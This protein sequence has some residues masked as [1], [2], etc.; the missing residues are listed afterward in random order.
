MSISSHQQHLILVTERVS[1][2]FSILG[3]SFVIITFL[4][5]P[6]F[7][8]P[9]NRMVFYASWGNLLSNVATMISRSGIDAGQDSSLCQSQSFLIQMFMPADSLWTFAMACNVYFT[10]RRRFSA[11]QLQKL[12]WKYF[13]L[14]YGIPAIPALVFLFIST[15]S[16]GR[17]YGPAELWCWISVDWDP[18][19]IACFYGPVWLIFLVTS[20]I[21]VS[22][23]LEIYKKRRDLR[24]A[25]YSLPTESDN[26]GVKTMEIHV[27]SHGMDYELDNVLASKGTDTTSASQTSATLSDNRQYTVD[28]SSSNAKQ[29][30]RTAKKLS[31]SDAAAWA[32]TKCAMLFFAALLITW[33]PSTIN[34]LYTLASSGTTSFPLCYFEALVLPLQGFWNAVIYVMTSSTACK[35][36]LL[37]CYDMIPP[38]LKFSNKRRNPYTGEN[39]PQTES[40]TELASPR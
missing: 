30:H 22:I 37:S 12:E 15:P 5:S 9:V 26:I 14:C 13:L 6:S 3:A 2:V 36:L 19:R 31:P 21:Y 16:K 4:A 7:H 23:G 39:A 1:S 38:Q 32:Y 8:R 17:V 27:S 11:E 33:V 40:T 35:R 24:E 28:I 25:T 10:F 29:N 20:L 18:L 34:R